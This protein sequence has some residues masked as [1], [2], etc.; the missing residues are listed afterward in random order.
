M[1]LSVAN[2]VQR[3]ETR[4]GTNRDGN[5]NQGVGVDA[6]MGVVS[7]IALVDSAGVEYLLWVSSAGKLMIGTR[8]NIATPDAAGTV[9]GG[10][11]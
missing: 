11:S 5:G 8:A 7:Y 9:V 4:F 10:Q 1:S 6:P 3:G 2:D